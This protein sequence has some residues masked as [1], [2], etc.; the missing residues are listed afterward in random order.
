MREKKNLGT[1]ELIVICIQISPNKPT[2][3]V[4]NPWHMWM[5]TSIGRLRSFPSID[6]W[7]WY[8]LRRSCAIVHFPGPEEPT[9]NVSPW[10]RRYRKGGEG[11]PGWV[12]EGERGEGKSACAVLLGDYCSER[13]GEKCVSQWGSSVWRCKHGGVGMRAIDERKKGYYGKLF[14]GENDELRNAHL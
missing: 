6:L 11:G 14:L 3:C 5:V 4:C 2:Q 8:I 9:I 13:C 10:A 12:G 7:G 1:G